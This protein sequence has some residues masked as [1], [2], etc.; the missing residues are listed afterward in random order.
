[1]HSFIEITKEDFCSL[2]PLLTLC[3]QSGYVL[4]QQGT[5]ILRGLVTDEFG[6]TIAGATV[7]GH[8]SKRHAKTATTNAEGLYA[9]AGLV[10][11]AYSVL[12]VAAGFAPFR[13][14]QWMSRRVD[15]SRSTLN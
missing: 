11:G 5:G 2:W 9:L 8:G 4:A 10:P 6:G 12:V 15:A 7:V 1:M 14:P 3:F 13:A